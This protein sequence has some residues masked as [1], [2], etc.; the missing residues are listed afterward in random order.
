MITSLL[1]CYGIEFS[2][3]CQATW[4]NELR[5]TLFGRYLLG[6][7]FLWSDILA[8][9]CGVFVAFII[10]RIALKRKLL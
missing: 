5:P 1:I 8:Y 10:E 7:G 2:Q 4:I 3:L 9:T 6:Q